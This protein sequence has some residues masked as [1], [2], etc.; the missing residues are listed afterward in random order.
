M[1]PRPGKFAATLLIALALFCAACS[2]SGANDEA[3]IRSAIEARLQ[4]NNNLNM[5]AFDTDI[6]QITITGDTAQAQVD[7]KLKT[8]PGDMQLT[9]RLQ[10]QSGNW[11]V[12]DS[13]GDGANPAHQG[14]DQTQIPQFP[15]SPGIGVP[16]GSHSL[17][18]TLRSFQQEGPNSGAPALPPGHP[19]VNQTPN[20]QSQ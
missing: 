11:V 3:L 20:T 6:K 8:G 1:T 7:F 15:T 16:G 13:N 17:S 5:G 10:K 12:L 18:D 2:K 14:L 4:H 9:Y 19:P